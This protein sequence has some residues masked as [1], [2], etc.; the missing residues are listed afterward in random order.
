MM[1]RWLHLVSMAR[2]VACLAVAATLAGTNAS[3]TAAKEAP[4][5]TLHVFAAAS[6]SKPFT[7]IAQGLERE[8]PGLRVRLVFA[9]SQQLAAQIEQGASADVFASADERWMTYVR[10]KDLAAG[11]PSVFAR[12][13][14]VVI[15]PKTNP[16]R[17][18]RLKDLAK[19][20]V[21]LVFGA[22]AVPVGTYSRIVLKNLG[23]D[24]A[25]GADFAT[26]V[27]RN[28]VSEEENVRAVV[29][30][31]QLGE[32]DAGIV[33]RSDVTKG[34]A[35]YIKSF[36]I[37]VEANVVATYPI[38]LVAGTRHAE[39]ARAFVERVLSPE[40]QAILKRHGFLAA[41]APAG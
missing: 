6:L 26:R 38:V 20:G 5:S 32:A 4:S 12:N 28:V 25:Y 16:A 34:A 40:G 2:A 18:G 14:L 31:V 29:S 11:E 33:Y 35:R 13:T 8:R 19:G 22:E 3:S 27:M 39:E 9:G 41:T 10:R 37:P 21:K 36:D 1:S 30:K 24:P 23:K 17:I 15:V 7:E